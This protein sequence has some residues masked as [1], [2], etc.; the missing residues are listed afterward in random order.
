MR[1]EAEEVTCPTCEGTGYTDY[2]S[3]RGRERKL[4]CADCNAGG[5]GVIHRLADKQRTMPVVP[6]KGVGTG[7]RIDYPG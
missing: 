7:E 5:V 2:R 4:Q 1:T 3:P 6:R